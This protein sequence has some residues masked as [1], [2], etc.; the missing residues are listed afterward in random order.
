M[1][2]KAKMRLAVHLR[3]DKCEDLNTVF[4]SEVPAGPVS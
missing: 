1:A 4:P 3:K 2:V